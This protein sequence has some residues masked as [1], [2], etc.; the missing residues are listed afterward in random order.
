MANPYDRSEEAKRVVSNQRPAPPEDPVNEG[1]WAEAERSVRNRNGG[2]AG[3]SPEGKK[4][5]IKKEYDQMVS[6]NKQVEDWAG[7]DKTILG[8]T[9]EQK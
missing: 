7:E 2:F 1:T 9:D 4:A 5:Q 8:Q 3:V 6:N